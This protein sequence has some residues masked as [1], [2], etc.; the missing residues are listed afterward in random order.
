V[1]GRVIARSSGS[2][3]T[4]TGWFALLVV[5]VAGAVSFFWNDYVHALPETYGMSDDVLGITWGVAVGLCALCGL[6]VG[7]TI[8]HLK[9]SQQWDALLS[10][11]LKPRALFWA[12]CLPCV[13]DALLIAVLALSLCGMGLGLHFADPKAFM[14][15]TV[16]MGITLFVALATSLFASAFTKGTAK[17]MVLSVIL[18]ALLLVGLIWLETWLDTRFTVAG[19]DDA[20]ESVSMEFL[21]VFNAPAPTIEWWHKRSFFTTS[22][23]GTIIL[24]WLGWWGV[25][26]LKR[27]R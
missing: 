11:P 14:P 9:A 21:P 8:S 12:V 18:S 1:R 26:R 23:I 17:A 10:L 5:G 19:M 24:L 4:L 27:E 7:A 2:R 3:I 13:V 22:V 20:S 16:A 6:N 25:R 15:Y